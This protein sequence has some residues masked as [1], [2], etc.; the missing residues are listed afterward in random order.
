MATTA[1]KAIFFDLDN[2]LMDREALFR[3][4]AQTFYEE[5]LSVMAKAP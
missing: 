1:A 5:H 3:R 4:V 2:T